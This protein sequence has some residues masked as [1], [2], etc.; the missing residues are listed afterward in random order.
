MTVEI[1]PQKLSYFFDNAVS[2]SPLEVTPT[3]IEC[4]KVPLLLCGNTIGAQVNRLLNDRGL[5]SL[6]VAGNYKEL[7]AILISTNAIHLFQKAATLDYRRAY[8]HWMDRAVSNLINQ[9][10]QTPPPSIFFPNT[11]DT[12]QLFFDKKLTGLM[13]SGV[14]YSKMAR[15]RLFPHRNCNCTTGNT[16]SHEVSTFELFVDTFVLDGGVF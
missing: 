12:D 10:D 3:P 7:P 2:V 6:I 14:E 11:N 8:S 5:C 1:Q 16:C 15:V 9:V 13:H 4:V